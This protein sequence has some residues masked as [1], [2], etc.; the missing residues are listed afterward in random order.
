MAAGTGTIMVGVYAALLP[1]D[2]ATASLEQRSA[3]F[4][5]VIYWA[6]M[7]TLAI[8]AIRM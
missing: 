7:D 4:G 2:V 3:A 1:E 8:I 6:I 5:R